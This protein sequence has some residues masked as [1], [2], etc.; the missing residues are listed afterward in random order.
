[1]KRTRSPAR[2][3]HNAYFNNLARRIAGQINKGTNF[4]LQNRNKG[5][6]D[7]A[8]IKY[9][10]SMKRL[11][12][13]DIQTKELERRKGHLKRLVALLNNAAQ[14]KKLRA[15]EIQAIM[16]PHIM[17][18]LPW[19]GFPTIN[20]KGSS[21]IKQ[22]RHYHNANNNFFLRPMQRFKKS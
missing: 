22:Y 10:N 2:E 4:H 7:K 14:S 21:S 20:H 12:L 9:S 3:L 11:I 6:F 15:T 19:R 17:K 13:Q 1:M 18:M 16:S 8:F 5:P